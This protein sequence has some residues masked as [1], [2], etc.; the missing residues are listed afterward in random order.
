MGQ[1]WTTWPT[2]VSG[3]A[4]KRRYS[5]IGPSNEWTDIG[6]RGSDADGPLGLWAGRTDIGPFRPIPISAHQH[7][8]R[9]VRSADGPT[10]GTMGRSRY[11]AHA[12]GPSANRRGFPGNAF[13]PISGP[14]AHQPGNPISHGLRPIPAGGPNGPTRRTLARK[15][16]RA[17]FHSP[18]ISAGMQAGN[19][20]AIATVAASM[21]RGNKQAKEQ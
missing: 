3:P 1:P 10:T 6:S 19:I 17:L 5:D 16:A 12:Y 18:S 14:R 13:K 7:I 15:C 11:R 20:Q 8:R 4:Q 9:M 21:V 2:V